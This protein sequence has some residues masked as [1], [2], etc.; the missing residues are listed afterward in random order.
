MTPGQH[1]LAVASAILRERAACCQAIE[2]MAAH[3]K[4]A[5]NSSDE[6]LCLLDKHDVERREVFIALG[7]AFTVVQ[8]E[9]AKK[10]PP[11]E[12]YF[13]DPHPTS[14]TRAHGH[15]R[16]PGTNKCY[17][18]ALS[19]DEGNAISLAGRREEFL[20]RSEADQPVVVEGGQ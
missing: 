4:D 17:C 18:G 3:W 8:I 7:R 1:Q 14:C 6:L 19:F 20:R 2:A 12:Y 5:D 15:F 16:A 11:K 13:D 9:E 10:H